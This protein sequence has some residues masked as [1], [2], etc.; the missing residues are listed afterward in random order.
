MLG[1]PADDAARFHG[2]VAVGETGGR[3]PLG[4]LLGEGSQALVFAVPGAPL[5]PPCEVKAYPAPA[6]AWTLAIRAASAARVV[7]FGETSRGVGCTCAC[8]GG[9]VSWSVNQKSF[10]PQ[11]ATTGSATTSH[12][13]PTWSVARLPWGF[14][15]TLAWCLIAGSLSTSK[16]GRVPNG[17][18][19]PAVGAFRAPS[20]GP[21]C[22][23]F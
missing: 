9:L 15:D 12:H 13:R 16:R 7:G 22:R 3:Y 20:G 10:G 6:P 23:L 14:S 2:V 8:A 17:P 19:A 11:P 1:D 21:G 4:E 5:V 18:R